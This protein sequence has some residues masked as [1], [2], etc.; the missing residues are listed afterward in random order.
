MALLSSDTFL[1]VLLIVASFM[2]K[3]KKEIQ[4]IEMTLAG[5]QIPFETVDVGKK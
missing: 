3:I 5:K 4:K 2:T 1:S